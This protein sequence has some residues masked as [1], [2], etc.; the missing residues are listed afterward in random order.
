M[1]GRPA[2]ARVRSWAAERPAAA[3]DGAGWLAL[4]VALVL[5]LQAGGQTRPLAVGLLL[6]LAA[7]LVVA[8][9]FRAGWLVIVVLLVAG[10][11]ARLDLLHAGVSDVLTV[12]AAADRL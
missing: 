9:R 7:T 10:C 6:L 3:T 5:A 8:L 11:A 1:T 12:T 4:V 2:F